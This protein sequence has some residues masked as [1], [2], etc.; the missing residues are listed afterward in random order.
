MQTHVN[1]WSQNK[2]HSVDV[3]VICA[4]HRD[5]VQT[6]NHHHLL[7]TRH[8]SSSS[9]DSDTSVIGHWWST[10]LGKAASGRRSLVI[11]GQR[12]LARLLV[13]AT[14]SDSAAK[15]I[16]KKAVFCVDNVNDIRAFVSS[17]SVDVLSHV[18]TELEGF[19]TVR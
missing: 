11:G 13:V 14:V 16:R 9:S 3:D 2:L 8:H 17:Q 4:G 19:E 5:G 18:L 7:H 1:T 15:S 10:L 12:Y 6:V